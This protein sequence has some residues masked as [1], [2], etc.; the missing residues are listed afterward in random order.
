[1]LVINPN[2][3]VVEPAP[4]LKVLHWTLVEVSKPPSPKLHPQKLIHI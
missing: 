2:P 3:K 4:R 1:M